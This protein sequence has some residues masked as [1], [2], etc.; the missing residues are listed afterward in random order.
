MREDF[1]SYYMRSGCT[2]RDTEKTRYTDGM[3]DVEQST[4]GAGEGVLTAGRSLRGSTNERSDDK[5]RMDH[6]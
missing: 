3:A 5:L 6:I 2:T 4:V 1:K